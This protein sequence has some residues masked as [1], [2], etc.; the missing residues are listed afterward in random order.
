MNDDVFID[1]QSI[2]VRLGFVYRS[3]VGDCHRLCRGRPLNRRRRCGVVGR[4]VDGRHRCGVVGWFRYLK[5]CRPGGVYR[6]T[7][8]LPDIFRVHRSN[9]KN[10]E[11]CG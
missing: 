3:Y 10:D 9:D 8:N 11:D 1:Q 5:S 7:W 4:S 2:F 6:F